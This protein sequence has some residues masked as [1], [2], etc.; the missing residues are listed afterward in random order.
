MKQLAIALVLLLLFSFSACTQQEAPHVVKTYEQTPIEQLEEVF[1]RGEIVTRAAYCEMSDGTWR[2][3]EYTYV[4]RLV[5]TGRMHNAAK[6]STYVILSNRDDIT[7]DMAWKASGLSSNM[8][9]YFK[10]EDAIIVGIG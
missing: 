1:D 3:G 5:I 2:S 10:P 8:N 7:F 4:H 6:D 9:D